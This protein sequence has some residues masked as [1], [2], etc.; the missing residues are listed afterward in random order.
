MS[1]V[2]VFL[3]TPQKTLRYDTETKASN[4]CSSVAF[5]LHQSL[6]GTQEHIGVGSRPRVFILPNGSWAK[7][8]F[9]LQKEEICMRRK[10]DL[11]CFFLTYTLQYLLAVSLLQ[12]LQNAFSQPCSKI[13]VLPATTDEAKQ[14]S[15]ETP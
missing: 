5:V 9:Q 13:F 8:H 3:K 12:R 4:Q 2:D 7:C 10:L 15:G 6:R 14:A 1:D 11:M